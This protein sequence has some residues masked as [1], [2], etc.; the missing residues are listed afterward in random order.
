M[1]KLGPIKIVIVIFTFLLTANIS[2]FAVDFN[3]TTD[4]VSCIVGK[5]RIIVTISDADPGPYDYRLWDGPPLSGGHV[6]AQSLNNPAPTYVFADWTAATYFV[7][8]NTPADPAGKIHSVDLSTVQTQVLSVTIS[9]LQGPTCIHSTDAIMQA[10]PAGGNPPYSYLWSANAGSQ[11]TQIATGLVAER[12]YAVTVNDSYGCGPKVAT[13]LFYESNPTW[14]DSIP[15]SLN[16]GQIRANQNVC[17]NGNPALLTNFT[18]PSGGR[19]AYTYDWEYELASD[20]GNWHSLGQNSLTYDPP[21]GITETT[22]YRRKTT[23]QC[24]VVYSNTITITVNPLPT[25]FNVTGGGSYCAGG[26][27]VPVGLSGSES[28]VNYELY[29]GGAPTGNIVAGTGAAISFGNQTIAGTYTVVATNASTTCQ[30]T[31]NGS[32][33]VTINPLPT[34]YNVTGGGSYCAGG[35][36]V[37]VGLSGSDVGI[38]YELYRGGSPTGNIV[39]GTGAAISF[40]NQTTAG[41]Y[42]VVATNTVTTCQNTMNGNAVVTINPLPTAYNVTGGGS[43]CTGGTGVPVGLSGSQAGVDYELYRDGAPTG[44][45][46][47]GTGSP[48]SFGNQTTA[49]TYTV[50]ATNTATT[51]QNTMN[52]SAVVSINPLPAIFDVTGGGHYC[53]GGAGVVI[54]LTGSEAGV[55]YELYRGGLATGVIVAGT[56]AAITFPNQTTAGTYTVVATNTSTGCQN[57]MN[58]NAVVTVDPL[59]TA[60][61]V[62]GGGSYCTGGAGVPVG[63][64]SSDAGINYELYRDGGPTG[65]I[66]AG[67]GASISFGNQTTAGT[68]TVV[69]TNTVTTCQNTMTGSVTVTV[70]PLPTVFNVT[71]GGSYCAGGSGVPVGLSGSESGVNYELYRGGAPTGNIVAGT[72]AAI[73]FGNQTIAGTYTVVATN[74]STTCQ[75]TMNGNA[76]VTIDPLP[77]A[78][79]VTGGGSYCAGSAGV[80]VGLSGSDAGINYELYRNGSPTGNIVAGTGAAISFGNQ[81]TAGTYTVVATNTAT[82]CQNTMTGSVTVTVNPLPTAYNMTGGGSYCSG[83]AGVAVG[84]SGSQVGV[85]YELY[86]NGLPTG[87]IVAGT[88][89]AISFGNQT[90]AGTYTAVATNTST[91]CQRNMN[92]SRIVTVNPLPA[93]FNVTGGGSY[94]S[95]GSGVPIGLSGS[96]VGINYE[97]YRNSV[98]TGNIVPGTGSSISFGNQTVAGTYTVVATNTSTNCQ[99]NMNGS[100]IVSINPLPTVFNVNGGG[101]YCSG[102]TGV[103]VG[104]SGSQVGINYELYRDGLTTGIIVPGTGSPISFGNQTTAGTYTVVAINGGT[105]CTR[106]MNGSAVVV[107]NPLPAI[108]N[109]TGGGPG[110]ISTG[111]TVGLDGSETG[112]SYELYRD[113]GPT[114]NVVNGTGSA[115]SFG[116]QIISGT[117]TVV[118][119][120]ATTTC[121]NT[122]NGSAVITINPLPSVFNITGGGSYCV[123]GT[124]VP[125]GLDGSEVGVDYELYLNLS[126]TGIIVS[127]TG[128]SISFGNQ[129]DV[130]SY[131]VVATNTLTL[132]TNLMNG[133]RTITTNP[134]PTVYD[135]TG[136]GGYCAGTTAPL[137]GL[138]GSQ[139]N[140]NYELYR[141]GLPT[142]TIVAGTG[143]AISFGNQSVAG[144]YTVIATNTITSCQNTMNGSVIVTINANPTVNIAPVDATVCQYSGL[145][146][147]GNPA[148]GTGP[149]T[150]L[151]T[152]SGAAHLDQINI[153]TPLFNSPDTDSTDVTVVAAPII[154]AGADSAVICNESSYPITGASVDNVSAFQWSTSGTGV[155]DDPFIID[156][157]YTPSFDDINAGIVVLY[158][159]GTANIP[160]SDATDSIVLVIPPPVQPSIG[161]PAPY[162]I[163]VNTKIEVCLST[164]DHEIPSD[165]GYYLIAPDGSTIMTLKRAPMEIDFFA[166]PCFVDGDVID[167]CF[168]TELPLSDTLDPCAGAHPITGN[169]AA[170]GDWSILYGMNPAQGGWA[171]MVKDTAAQRGGLDGEI[172]EASIAFTDTAIVTGAPR[173]INYNSGPIN[174]PI[175]EPARNSYNVPI[176][177]SVSCADACDAIALVNTTGGVPPYISYTWNP[178][179]AAGNGTDSVLLCAGTYNLTVTDAMGCTGNTSVIVISPPAIVIDAVSYTDTLDCFGDTTGVISVQASGGTGS[180]TFTLLPGDIPSEAIDSGYFTNLAAGTYTVHIE[181]INGCYIDTILFIRQRPQLLLL[182]AE[183]TDSVFCS[184]DTN[185]RI[186]ATASG[187]TL[188]YTYILEPVS[189]SNSTGIF[190]NLGPGSY[191]V[192]LTDANNCDTINSD[193][194]I[195]GVPVPLVIDTVIVTPVT[196]HGSNGELTVVILGGR[197]PYDVSLNGIV[198]ATGVQDT[199]YLFPS[200]GSYDISVTDALGCSFDWPTTINLVDPPVLVID[201][202]RITPVTTCYTDPTGEI[203]AYA[204]GGT[205]TIE[206]SIDGVNY[207]T[208]NLFTGLMGG[209]RTL[210]IRDAN[211]CSLTIDTTIASPPL[212]QGNPVV[213][214]VEGNNLG[215]IHLYPTG[216]TPYTVGEGYRYSIDGGPLDTIPLF[217]SLEAGTYHVHVEDSLG[218]PW[219]SDITIHEVN[220]DIT[221]IAIDADCYGEPSG[222]IRVFMNNGTTPFTI[223]LNGEIAYANVTDYFSQIGSVEPGIY[224][225]Y[226]VDNSG[227]YN[228]STVTVSSPPPLVIHRQHGNISCNE[229]NLD[230]THPSDGYISYTTEGGAGSFTYTWGDTGNPDSTRQNLPVGR[231]YVTIA[232][233]NSCSLADTTDLV[234]LDTLAALIKIYPEDPNGY[235]SDEDLLNYPSPSSD[236]LCYGSVWHL[237]ATH[238][239]FPVEYTWNPDTLLD[240]PADYI[241]PDV[242]Y[243]VLQPAVFTLRINNNR[244]MDRDS[245]R[246]WVYDTIGIQITTDAYRLEDDIFILLGQPLNLSCTDGYTA[247]L[248]QAG[249]EFDDDAIQS[250]VLIPQDSQ[251]VIV[252]GTTPLN[253]YERDT[254]NIKIR[255]LLNE[256]FD[257]FTPN[258][259]GRNDYWIIPNADQYPNLEVFI[260]NRWGQQVFYSKPYGTDMHHTWN[261][262][263]QKNGKDLPIGSYYYII[264]PN[265]GTQQPLTGTVTIVR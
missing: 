65:N 91:G 126:P 102:G 245:I 262:K 73:S 206:Y 241:A 238:H 58:G 117:Y 211:M 240:N 226:V 246:L 2:L 139:V 24:G 78:Y 97:L 138:S 141:N 28:G 133:T 170:T 26:S 164:D 165:I 212:L 153:V 136:G 30:S 244:C 152:G 125:I 5:G 224:T 242:T 90:L 168:T 122:M 55:N 255:Q 92:G 254:V 179:P 236:T 220:L 63:L 162:L 107:E 32:V 59:P 127:G 213:T 163:G 191:M 174:I 175:Y 167:L 235:I 219:D 53:S 230:G 259:D 42:T 148:G 182:S 204:S 256:V 62:T 260:F 124:G 155:F 172:T 45:I 46:V 84:L 250:P 4:A 79:N 227:R 144:T 258:A 261:G 94:C 161:S 195:L 13:I 248:W 101:E 233:A 217:D 21:A 249:D 111:V 119:T 210:F 71:G 14:K 49:G 203:Y 23:N 44:N 137:V 34:A 60:Y 225:V 160:C 80:P 1:R 146:Y 40:G 183:V 190:N 196:C 237:L 85:N 18:S 189:V 37:P 41:T 231:Y 38:N 105:G 156:P 20:P 89:A 87:N 70:N 11:T 10:N 188:P 39:A 192:R 221:V 113:G 116:Y 187:G 205:G 229:Y 149:Y 75:N 176:G 52:G 74:A 83:G 106:N 239:Y 12:T 147:N 186:V 178:L 27:G 180:L 207:Q 29:R 263:S 64:S 257:V 31:M 264:K 22:N 166:P 194:L 214:D 134:L 54:G 56:G 132:C 33:V 108:F 77:T 100:V 228:D 265:D 184:G 135:I 158:L 88:G 185:G 96:E 130:G 86:R 159:T 48:I 222:T 68:Y 6:I 35:A 36:G 232:D 218:C 169:F 114:G 234:P 17:I 67:T 157:T 66:V 199:S 47:S 43:Y 142:G 197:A 150:S 3:L 181:D 16:G 243:T 103:P 93:V 25:I 177:L 140:V 99:N 69:A 118:A 193:T 50:V 202:I 171:V 208:S 9:V 151:W 154:N 112:V 120:N 98:P 19:G 143:S 251:M 104:L 128:G 200:P 110:C 216:G 95:G 8:V 15:D 109:V 129:T 123:G 198:E 82:T 51:C 223:Y 81:T 76:V 61:N 57:T 252:R 7:S 173:T 209:P 121:Q 72:G 145:A 215:S 201:S 115:I 131:T 247:Y 253:C